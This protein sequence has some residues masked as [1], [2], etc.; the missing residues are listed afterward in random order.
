MRKIESEML[1]H[2]YVFTHYGYAGTEHSKFSNTEVRHTGAYK[3]SVLLHGHEI[4][5]VTQEPSRPKT[6]EINLCGWNTPTTRSR[7]STILQEYIPGCKGV[8]TKQ[9]QAFVVYGPS[10]HKYPVDSE[11]WYI[12]TMNGVRDNK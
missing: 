1:R 2:I 6:V 10:G 5:R 12:C 7:L 4:A 8:A 9:G 3:A 11:S